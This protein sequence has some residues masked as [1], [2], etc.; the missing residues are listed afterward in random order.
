MKIMMIKVIVT[1]NYQQSEK[2]HLQEN[3]YFINFIFYIN[4]II[5]TALN[6]K[7]DITFLGYHS[8]FIFIHQNLFS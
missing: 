1:K 3:D 6:L 5:L 2:K 4:E 7:G 8:I